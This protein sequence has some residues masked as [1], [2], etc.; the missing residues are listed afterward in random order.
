MARFRIWER[1]E[2]KQV[3]NGM[4]GKKEQNV[5]E[6]RKTIENGEKF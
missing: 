2:R 1:R 5:S 3:L 6:E 4:G